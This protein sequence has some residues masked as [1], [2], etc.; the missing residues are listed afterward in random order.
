MGMLSDREI[1]ELVCGNNE[2]FMASFSPS[3]EEAAQSQL[4]T[5][6]QCLE[7]IGSKVR[8][9]RRPGTMR[10]PPAEEAQDAL[11]D[12]VLAHVPVRGLNFRPKALF[13]AWMI[14]RVI[15]AMHDPLAIDDR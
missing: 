12:L 14:R 4:F 10:R 9:P 15:T 1:V 5:R 11:A 6:Q 2:E 8:L 3:L 13:L 7:H